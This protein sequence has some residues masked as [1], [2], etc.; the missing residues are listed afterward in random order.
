MT[1]PHIEDGQSPVLCSLTDRPF[2]ATETDELFSIK[3]ANF[4]TRVTN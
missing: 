3:L 2:T 4:I 1:L